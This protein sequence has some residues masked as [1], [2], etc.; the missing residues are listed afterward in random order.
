MSTLKDMFQTKCI[1]HFNF[2]EIFTLKDNSA[3]VA[4]DLHNHNIVVF[5]LQDKNILTIYGCETP[6]VV[7]ALLRVNHSNEDYH[8]LISGQHDF[9]L[10]DP[11][12]KK[13]YRKLI[14]KYR[15]RLSRT[16]QTY[17]VSVTDT[18][19]LSVLALQ[20]DEDLDSI[21]IDASNIDELCALMLKCHQERI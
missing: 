15:K 8:E 3:S 4:L 17:T 7:E 18:D 14:K 21:N 6:Y 10:K 2:N 9:N 12:E 13:Q 19:S 11:N 16:T 20:D 1:K 5:N